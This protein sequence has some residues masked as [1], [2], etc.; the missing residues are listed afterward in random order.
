MQKK[1][2]NYVVLNISLLFILFFILGL[3]I[4]VTKYP[5]RYSGDALQVL[6]YLKMIV[7]G[8]FSFYS[9]PT[10]VYLSL[11]F[12]FNGADFPL[13]IA[14]NILFVKLLSTLT[15][16]IF[17]LMN[18]Y[19]ISSYFMISNAMFWVLS[20]LRVYQYLAIAISILYAFIPFHYMRI[21]HFW[22][23]NYFLLPITVYYL[24]LLWK[25]TPLFFRKNIKQGGYC[26]SISAKNFIIIIVLATFSVWNFYY[27]FF[28]VIFIVAV[29]ISAYYYRKNKYHIYS[30]LLMV[31][32]VTVPF[33]INFAPYKLEQYQ[34]GINHEVAKRTAG[35]SEVYGLKIAQMLLPVY[36]HNYDTFSAIRNDYNKAPLINENGS[37][38]LGLF[39]SLGFLIATIYM[40]LQQ[41]I[42]SRIKKLAVIIYTGTIF[43]TIGG[44]S[45]IF[46]LLITPQ[47]RGYNRISIYIATVSLIITA[48]FLNGLLKKYPLKNIIKIIISIM[49]VIIGIYDQVPAYMSLRNATGEFISDRN[50]I[51]DIEMNLMSNENKKVFQ[52]PYMSYPEH[53][54]IHNMHDYAQSVGYLHST[55]IKWSYG[56]VTGRESD[57]WIKSL[58]IKPISEQISIL[59]SSGFS[60]VYIDR[61]GYVDNG[62]KLEQSIS[63]ILNIQPIISDDKLKSFFK[64]MPTGNK[65]YDLT[66]Y[67]SLGKSFYGWEGGVGVFGWTNGNTIMEL[68]GPGR[69]R[70]KYNLKFDVGTIMPRNIKIV[71]DGIVIHKFQL[72]QGEVKSINLFLELVTGRHELQI[73]TDKAAQLP[74]NGDTRKMAFSISNLKYEL[75]VSQ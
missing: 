11:P 28:Y 30:G 52:L 21:S 8:S 33:I 35:E 46:A 45:S 56:A 68:T 4:E 74:G 65:I 10:S 27:T 29:T 60:G 20:R 6:M 26:F 40:L 47:I 9:Y 12:G 23:M 73:M 72:A 51:D 18:I 61:R 54:A 42:F 2:I 13:P 53:V 3:N 43:A 67:P 25:K 15:T 66:I 5:I 24:L 38:T 57:G 19:I 34:T 50:F 17:V 48:L 75:L 44:Y 58:I 63:N 55:D 59:Q 14:A 32:F 36:G 7:Q 71:Q 39:A 37:S 22:F 16:N 64:L 31:V 49:I 1:V 41:R 69:N 62:V 70:R